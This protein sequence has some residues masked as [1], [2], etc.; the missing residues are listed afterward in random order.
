[1]SDNNEYLTTK[2]GLE[3]LKEELKER[4]TVTREKIANVLNEMRSQETLVKMMVTPWL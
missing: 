4:E 1:M 3:K 2:E